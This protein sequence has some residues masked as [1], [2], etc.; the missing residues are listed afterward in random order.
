MATIHI[1]DLKA[2]AI[3]GTH[4]W[5]RKNKQDVII[6]VRIDYDADK[7]S[8]TDR[9]GDALDYERISQSILRIVEGSKCFL[10]EKLTD[11]VLQGILRAPKVQKASVRIDKPHALALARYVSYEVSGEN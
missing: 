10:L 9:L 4:P 8:K 5:E 6:T 7:A 1:V 11:K 3:I 2:R